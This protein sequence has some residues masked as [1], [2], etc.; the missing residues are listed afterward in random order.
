MVPT[1][2]RRLQQDRKNAKESRAPTRRRQFRVTGPQHCRET[3]THVGPTPA[4]GS[5][6]RNH[7]VPDN[8]TL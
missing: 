1:K 4:F 6:V 8:T 2:Q 7:M 5:R 3:Q